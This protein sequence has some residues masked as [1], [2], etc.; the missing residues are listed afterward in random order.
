MTI[1][2]ILVL[3][4]VEH[5]KVFDKDQ[6]QEV[7]N[8]LDKHHHRQKEHQTLQ[9][10]GRQIYKIFYIEDFVN[11]YIEQWQKLISVQLCMNGNK[12][13]NAR[14]S[15]CMQKGG[16]DLEYKIKQN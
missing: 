4:L 1:S 11:K 8:Y 12:N 16:W 9:N 7:C 3:R 13:A 2:T 5:H 14:T 6:V 15:H 10:C